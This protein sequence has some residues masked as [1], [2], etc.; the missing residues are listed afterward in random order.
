[1]Q[2][3][4]S[5]EEML[6]AFRALGGTADNVCLDDQRELSARD[7][8]QPILLLVPESLLF[9]LEA[10][11]LGGSSLRLKDAE[12]A[13]PAVRNFLARYEDIFGPVIFAHAAAAIAALD[14]LP[15]QLN[16]VLSNDF[17]MHESFEGERAERIQRRF[18]ESRAIWRGEERLLAPVLELARHDP[19]GLAMQYAN[20]LTTA[21]PARNGVRVF[22]PFH[23]ALA[24]FQ[25]YGLAAG[26]PAAFSLPMS[27]ASDGVEIA[28]ARKLHAGER[29]VD[30]TVPHLN[31]IGRNRLELSH[32]ML[33]HSASPRLARGIFRTRMREADVKD[34]DWH[35]DRITQENATRLLK[36]LAMLE[37]KEGP[38]ASLRRMA[39]YQLEAMSF[40]MGAREI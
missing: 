10:F 26:Q 21:G 8:E 20:G 4:W 19:N 11:E 17:G 29:R 9:P 36:L 23:D 25:R 15:A 39:R 13:S 5:A 1:M 16:E 37:G 30:V 12:A 31:V 24:I 7:P 33:G 28:I 6:N 3:Q 38:S 14:S 18:V 2:G 34:P 35:F 22:H 32:L 40:S 27:F